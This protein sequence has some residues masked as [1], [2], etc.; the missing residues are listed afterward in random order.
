MF[1]DGKP[2]VLNLNAKVDGVV[3]GEFQFELI[4]FQDEDIKLFPSVLKV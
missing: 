1:E 4:E 2:F 3:S